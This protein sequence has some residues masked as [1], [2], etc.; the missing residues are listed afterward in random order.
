MSKK[1]GYVF[2]EKFMWHQPHFVQLT[3][4]MQP[5][6]HWENVE[7]KRRFHNLLMA[8][9]LYKK[10]VHLQ[11][12]SSAT[13]EQLQLCHCQNYVNAVKEKSAREEGG[14]AGPETPISQFGF[15]IAALA[16]GGVLH[17]VDEIMNDT[18]QCAYALIR[19]PGHHATRDSAMGFC[20]F[21]N[22]AIAAKHILQTYDSIQKVA[23]VDYDVHH[24]NG[25]QDMFYDNEQ[26]LF[27]SIH[28]DS[29]YP[30]NS[31]TLDEIGEGNAIGKTVNIPLPPGS[32]RGA[33][34]YTFDKIVVPSLQRFDPDFILVSSGF[35]AS[36]ADP[37]S[38]MMLSSEDFRYMT[39]SLKNVAKKTSCNGKMMFVHEGGYSEMY[40]PFCGAAV[41]EELLLD[42]NDNNDDN[43]T[44]EDPFLTE[45]KSWGGQDLQLHQK[46]LVNK[47]AATHNLD[48]E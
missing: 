23:I 8:S 46:Q 1:V 14:I 24:G 11:N 7:T 16:V 35:D 38:A 2:E 20:V 37:L 33:Y 10:L 12:Y 39:K 4:L 43:D 3:P 25:T 18:V 30:E 45:V 26:I 34:K 48:F 22:V 47:V 13:D 27:I 31:G 36:Y 9:G 6:Q 40:V 21:N 42:D 17:A 29:N 5:F 32:G 28:Q 15:D 19:P 44:I 41:I